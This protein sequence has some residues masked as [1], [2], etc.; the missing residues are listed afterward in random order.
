[1]A[2]TAADINLVRELLAESKAYL[3]ESED[4]AQ[5]GRESIVRY[6]GGIPE[7]EHD[8][9]LEYLNRFCSA[10]NQNVMTLVSAGSHDLGGKYYDS[11]YAQNGSAI[12]NRVDGVIGF[13]AEKDGELFRWTVFR[14]SDDAVLFVSNSTAKVAPDLTEASWQA[15]DAQYQGDVDS[16]WDIDWEFD[17]AGVIEPVSGTLTSDLVLLDRGIMYRSVVNPMV[18]NGKVR[19]GIWRASASFVKHDYDGRYKNKGSWAIIQ[20]LSLE[21]NSTAPIEETDS[22]WRVKGG[23]FFKSGS[24]NLVLELPYCDPSRVHEMAESLNADANVF[25]SSIYTVNSGLLEGKWYHVDVDVRISESDGYGTI[26]W[27]LRNHDNEDFRFVYQANEAETHVHFFKRNMPS[28]GIQDF[29]DN[30]YFDPSGNFYVSTDGVNYTAMNGETAAGLVPADA[31]LLTT[32]VG[33]RVIQD[34]TPRPNDDRGEIQLHVLLVFFGEV[35]YGSEAAGEFL[36]EYGL[37]EEKVRYMRRMLSK[38]LPSKLDLVGRYEDIPAATYGTDT[39]LTGR[40]IIRT[41]TERERITDDGRFEYDLYEIEQNA[42]IEVNDGWFFAGK[43]EKAEPEDNRLSTYRIQDL[44]QN[45]DKMYAVVA[46]RFRILTITKERKFFVR[47][48]TAADIAA[49]KALESTAPT[50]PADA[51]TVFS[52]GQARGLFY[53]ERSVV[54][55]GAWEDWTEAAGAFSFDTVRKISADL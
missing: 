21:M 12:Y 52:D 55:K 8:I 46:P 19:S 51:D 17:S 25:N 27:F 6:W 1:M 10:N 38:T 3:F 18:N 29:H 39:D 41:R 36:I 2:L 16:E 22:N 13:K 23:E 43:A 14:I 37:P 40:R 42:P 31:K 49:A 44:T 9:C 5:L 53:I 26:L 32:S 33:G 4:A 30:Y 28:D 24:R 50:S 47:Q 15:Q 11:G 20:T 45:I 54:S 48:P 35:V 34:Y 7:T